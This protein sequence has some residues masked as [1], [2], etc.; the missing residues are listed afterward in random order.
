MY[1]N[2]SRLKILEFVCVTSQTRYA[3][4]IGVSHT[5]LGHVTEGISSKIGTH[6]Y[7]K[8]TLACIKTCTKHV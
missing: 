7:M 6:M 4:A 5:R 3:C 1:K 8:R 2:L